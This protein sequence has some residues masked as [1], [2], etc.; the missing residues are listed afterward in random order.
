MES[1]DVV[2]PTGK[3]I[4]ESHYSI[5]YTIRSIIS[6]DIQPNKIIVVENA[7]NLGVRE[8]LLQQFGNLVTIVSGLEKSP[9]ISF[10]RNIGVKNCDS[11]I[12]IFMDDDV[13]LG[14]NNYFSLVNK[15]MRRNDFCCG[16]N[17]LWT[18]TDWHEYLSLDY[19]MNHNLQILKSRAF[20]PTSIERSTGNRNCSEYTYIG[21]FGAIQKKVFET[22]GG[23]DE[24]YEG[25]LYQDTDLMMRLCYYGYSYEVLSYT[26]MFCFHL[27][28]PAE[29]QQY[30]NINKDKYLQKQLAMGIRFSNTN[31]FGRFDDRS[32]YA[33]IT[34]IP[35]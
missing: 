7:P 30:R 35:N 21:N 20:R 18:N 27:S 34:A 33:I 29:K 2:I 31:F 26:D 14:Y 16:A 13:I 10:A 15:I 12:I 8:V 6:Q 4:E 17:R 3:N 11:D 23:F 25:W 24:T 19:P 9:N 28:H 32:N 5:C 1:F 22:I